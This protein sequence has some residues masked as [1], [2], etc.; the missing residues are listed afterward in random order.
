MISTAF[1]KYNQAYRLANPSNKRPNNH[2][3]SDYMIL[4]FQPNE[5]L[6]WRT[7]KPLLSK[8]GGPLAVERFKGS[9]SQRKDKRS[10]L[11]DCIFMTSN[12][13]RYEISHKWN[14]FLNIQTTVGTIINRLKYIINQMLNHYYI[15]LL[16]SKRQGRFL[17]L[18]I[19]YNS[20]SIDITSIPFSFVNL[21][22]SIN[23]N[24]W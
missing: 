1:W 4:V 7:K 9:Y 5:A 2:S 11:N 14:D 19:Y 8:R 13:R 24:F 16:T 21:F 15:L 6:L 22:I 3:L 18:V 12:A 20:S 17:V 23:P 10:S